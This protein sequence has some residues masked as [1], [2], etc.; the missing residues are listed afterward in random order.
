MRILIIGFLALM[1]WSALSTYVYVCKIRGFCY[2][3]SPLPV[4][5]ASPL[6]VLVSDSIP[7]P[8]SKEKTQIPENLVVYFEFDKSEFTCDS[9]SKN[10]SK[11]SNT[12]LQKNSLAKIQITG[13]TDATG[14]AN[15]NKNLGYMRAQTMRM[16]FERKGIPPKKIILV[17]KGEIEPAEDNNTAAGRAKNRRTVITINN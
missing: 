4:I 14:S 2:E 5:F 8:T 12:F 6:E 11:E 3:Q 17:S 9:I 16:F 15:Y 1:S 13:Y 7:G 10:Y